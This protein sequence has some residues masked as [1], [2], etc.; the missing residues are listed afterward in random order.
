MTLPELLTSQLTDPFRIGLLIALF[1]TMLRTRAAT[2]TIM[3]L[4]FGAVFVAVMLP[5]TQPK[6]QAAP[7]TSVIGAGIL[8]DVILL[9]II[10]G[11]W[12]LYSRSKS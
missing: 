9:A 12:T 11:A 1:Y 4:A 6:A 8:A 3:P 5:M 2:G 10:L 7:M